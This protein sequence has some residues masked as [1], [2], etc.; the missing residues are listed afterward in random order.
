[1][2][3]KSEVSELQRLL[4]DRHKCHTV[5]LYGSR[6]RGGA[7]PGS[8]W[9]V[10][11]IRREGASVRE[12]RPLGDG[13]LDAFVHPEAHFEKLDEGSLRFLNGK[14]LVDQHGFGAALL[15]RIAA[16]EKQG[17]PPLGEGDESAMRAWYPKMLA[18]IAR[19]DVEASYRRAWLLFDSLE[20]WFRLR[21]RWY[22]GPKESLAW[23]AANEPAVH[24]TFARAL[25]PAATHDDLQ[26]LVACVLGN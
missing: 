21:R 15:K 19:G 18:R 2:H 22:R 8:D 6:V 10:V 14:V 20:A 17:P 5:I 26:A 4:V 23:L 12:A 13:W 7:S 3:D 25:D 24:E 16:F 11:G 1:M 9:D